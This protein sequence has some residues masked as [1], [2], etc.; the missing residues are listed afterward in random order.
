MSQ[1]EFLTFS[2]G[3]EHY[4]LDILNVQEIRS[5]ERPT[6]IAQAQPHMLGVINLRGDVVPIM[7]LRVRMGLLAAQ[8][9]PAGITSATVIIFAV[10]NGGLV[11]FVVDAVSDVIAVPDGELRPLDALQVDG[12]AP[13]IS[14]IVDLGERHVLI[15]PID[16]LMQPLSATLEHP[17]LQ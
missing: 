3:A 2:V 17:T 7:D 11:G 14:H 16:C 6:R 4:G 5:F 1:Q 13:L 15:T 8:D 9:A 10:C 12:A